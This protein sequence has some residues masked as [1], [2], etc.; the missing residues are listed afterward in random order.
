MV[1]SLASC[2]ETASIDLNAVSE[3]IKKSDMFMAQLVSQNKDDLLSV[4][5]VDA[6]A[7]VSAEYYVTAEMTGE[8]WGVFECADAKAA[9]ALKEELQAHIDDL[10]ESYKGYMPAAVPTLESA[11]LMQKGQYVLIII[12][13]DSGAASTIANNYFA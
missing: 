8:E 1:F 2:G 6:S 4:I 13:N 12:A 5:G 9:Q 11:V 10:I 3:E 7:C